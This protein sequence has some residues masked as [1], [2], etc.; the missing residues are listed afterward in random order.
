MWAYIG[1]GTEVVDLQGRTVIPG[2]SD[3]HFHDAGGGPGVDLSKV[4]TMAELLAKIKEAAGKAAPGEIVRSNSDWHEAQ[5]TEQRT[6]LAAE[7]ETA[8]PGV[9][10]VIVR[11]G[12]SYFLNTTALARFNITTATPVPS[13]GAIPRDANGN[14]TGELVDRARNLVQ[15][16]PQ[17][18]VTVADL[19][20]QERVANSYG[21]TN[22]RIPGTSV[23]GYNMYRQLRDSG[24]STVRYSIMFRGTPQALA[25]AGIKQGDGDEWIKVWGIKMGVDGGFEGGFMTQPYQEPMGQGGT[26]FGLQTMTQAAFDAAVLAWNRA[27]WRVST[28]AVGD[29]AI[30]QVLKGYEAANADKNLTQAGWGFE[31]AFVARADQIPRMKALNLRMSVQDHL[32]LAAPSLKNY[33][34]TARSSQ[35]TPVR[36]YLDAGL[37]VAGGTDSAV[38]PLNPFWVMYHFI[39]RDTISDGVY[40]ANQAITREEALRLLTINYARLTDETEIKGSIEPNKLADF[41]VLS[42]DFMTIPAAQIEDLKALSTYVA[43]KKVYQDPGAAP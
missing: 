5:L 3:G 41:V 40:G 1:P 19:E 18:A 24:K 36:T 17:P 29:A 7:I 4:R 30:D 26:Y 14:L 23:T 39:T 20:A 28:H 22:L 13:G 10:V 38:I 21:L 8:A 15:L 31:H 35:V 34:G 25:T 43:G 11:G 37:M 33:W 2:L 27:G 12:H 6:P 32:Y 42:A 9:P 16:P